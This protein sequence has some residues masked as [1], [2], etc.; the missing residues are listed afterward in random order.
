MEL[1]FRVV[2]SDIPVSAWWHD[3]MMLHWSVLARGNGYHFCLPWIFRFVL[4]RLPTKDALSTPPHLTAP[5][6]RGAQAFALQL[7]PTQRAWV[8]SIAPWTVHTVRSVT[9]KAF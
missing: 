4:T 3:V 8:W 6:V 2:T 1:D 9:V 5:L 7:E